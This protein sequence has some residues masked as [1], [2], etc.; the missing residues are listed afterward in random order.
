MS[1]GL[2]LII[3]KRI[4]MIGNYSILLIGDSIIAGLSR[5]FNIWKR[6]FKP[7]YAIN[8]GISGDSVENILWRCKNLPSCPN[9]QNTV[10]MCGTN[11]IQHNSVEDVVDGMVE[12]ALSLRLI[13]H[14]I[15]FFLSAVFSLVIVTGQSIKFT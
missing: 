6:Y 3:N 14:P 12:I 2:I 15:V 4:M 1:T 10:I 8:C 13:Y 9:L 7:L 11:N 5:Y